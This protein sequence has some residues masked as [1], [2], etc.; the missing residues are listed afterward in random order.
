[1][2]FR[3]EIELPEA[4]NWQFKNFKYRYFVKKNLF[5]IGL[6]RVMSIFDTLRILEK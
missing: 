3:Y 1:M 5:L 6:Q 4:H 2:S